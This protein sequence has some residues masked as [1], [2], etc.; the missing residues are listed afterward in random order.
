MRGHKP[1]VCECLSNNFLI[2]IKYG[3]DGF[4]L[5]YKDKR[6]PC[7]VYPFHSHIARFIHSYAFVIIVT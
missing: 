7:V 6:S 1:E 2:L 4:Y 3:L 5:S